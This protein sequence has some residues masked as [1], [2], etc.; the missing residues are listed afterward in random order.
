MGNLHEQAMP[1]KELA[2][3]VA[4]LVCRKYCKLNPKRC[5]IWKQFLKTREEQTLVEDEFG[6]SCLMFSRLPRVRKP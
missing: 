3:Y 4:N 1:N 6:W 2:E 5:Y